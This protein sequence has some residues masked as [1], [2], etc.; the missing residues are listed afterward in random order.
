MS[1]PTA[2]PVRPMAADDYTQGQPVR[3]VGGN[4]M[5]GDHP[6]RDLIVAA[7]VGAAALWAVP[8]ALDF[9]TGLMEGG[10]ELEL[11]EDG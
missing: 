3:A 7:V 6:T 2:P 5:R 4:A 8:K 10:D 11:E 9:V 1:D